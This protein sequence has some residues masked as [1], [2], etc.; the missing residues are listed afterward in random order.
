MKKG[1]FTI[2]AVLFALLTHAQESETAYNFLRLPV[3]AHAAALGGE[4]ISLNADDATL[5]FHNPALMNFVAD[6]TI[7]LNYMTYMEGAKAASASFVRGVG[8]R[9]SWGVTA[10]Y[11]DYGKMKQTTYDNIEI[12]EFSAK[13]ICIGGAFAY[14]LTDMI[15]GGITAKFITSSIAD[16]HSMAVGV[17]IGLN[18]TDSVGDL[19]IAVA[20]KN[21]GGQVKAY[22][23]EFEKIPFD[24]QVGVTKRLTN[25]PFRFSATLSRLHDWDQGFIKHLA[26]GADVLLSET[27]YLAAGY[28]F[29]RAHEMKITEGDGSSS[30]GAGLSF[31]AGISLERFKLHIGYGKYHVSAYSLLFNASYTL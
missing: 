19:S 8:E 29:R 1:V 17:D 20:A 18:Y 10:Q 23:D 4:N 13:D 24:L 5:I 28:N 7:N 27:I 14:A 2:I 21:L 30:H 25:S 16:Y 11:L 3:S 9:A 6:K 31:G 12:G 15:S 26:L 22:D